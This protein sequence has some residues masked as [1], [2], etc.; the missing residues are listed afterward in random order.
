MS[1][2]SKHL[3]WYFQFL[4]AKM[5]LV[6]SLLIL[7]TSTHQMKWGCWGQR[8]IAEK[9]NSENLPNISKRIL[10]S[11]N[12]KG[13]LPPRLVPRS[14]VKGVEAGPGWPLHQPVMAGS[15]HTIGLMKRRL[16]REGKESWPVTMN[17]PLILKNNNWYKKKRWKRLILSFY[18][19]TICVYDCAWVKV[20]KIR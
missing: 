20:N 17:L 7:I 14:S 1:P 9:I 18:Y 13:Y 6:A 5:F 4:A 8:G 11:D 2:R 10:S 19:L 3:Q 15:P 16:Q 12:E